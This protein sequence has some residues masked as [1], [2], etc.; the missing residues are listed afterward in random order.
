MM[1]IGYFQFRARYICLVMYS[2]SKSRVGVYFLGLGRGSNFRG[3]PP[4]VFWGFL[5]LKFRVGVGLD[6]VIKYE[7]LPVNA[8]RNKELPEKKKIIW[9]ILKNAASTYTYN[10]FQLDPEEN[11]TI[12]CYN[13]FEKLSRAHPELDYY[14]EGH[15]QKH[16]LSLSMKEAQDNKFKWMCDAGDIHSGT[17]VLDIGSGSGYLTACF[18]E[19]VKVYHK[20]EYYRGKVVGL[21]RI[22]GLVID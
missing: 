9:I 13:W 20:D 6:F 16:D 17:R 11:K 10:F 8:L 15:N 19:A 2:G 18:G 21:E 1:K 3:R 14:T 12:N 5:K 4:R 22:S 7:V